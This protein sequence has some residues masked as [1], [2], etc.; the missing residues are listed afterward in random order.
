[1]SKINIYLDLDETLIY[2]IDI[3]RKKALPSTIDHFTYHNFE[4]HY[5]ILERPNLQPFLDW[6]FENFSVSVWS[7]A[8]PDYVKYI[9]DH[10]IVGNKYKKRK[11]QRVLN[12][13]NCDKSQLLYGEDALKKLAML[14]EYY[15]LPNHTVDNTILLDD[16]C[17]N[18]RAQ[19]ENSLRIKKFIGKHDDNELSKVKTKLENV[20]A[21]YKTKK[22]IDKSPVRHK[23][24]IK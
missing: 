6:L 22:R 4:N 15:K 5:V 8:S 1:M 23:K 14:W 19:P 16:L 10:V 18:I 17:L 3:S 7:A 12:S 24:L 9:V 11:L 13:D 20:I 2:S 21:N